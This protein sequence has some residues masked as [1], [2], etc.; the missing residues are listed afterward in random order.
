MEISPRGL[1]IEV[2]RIEV[3]KA[4]LIGIFMNNMTPGASHSGGTT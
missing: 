1:E 3:L 4:V 2:G